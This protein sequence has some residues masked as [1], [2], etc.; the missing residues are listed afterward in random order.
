MGVAQ[1]D[2]EAF[3]WFRKAAEKGYAPAENNM[4]FI[5]ANGKGVPV[6]GK[7]ALRWYRAAAD[8]GVVAAEYSI[9]MM[10]LRGIA[11]A[12]DLTEAKQWLRR[13]AQHGSM[14][15]EKEIQIAASDKDPEHSPTAKSL[16]GDRPMHGKAPSHS[17][18]SLSI[19]SLFGLPAD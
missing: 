19:N 18:G 15:A 11:V 12:Q 7:Q 3:A 10:Y 9:G 13:A 6:D 4:G 17:V 2:S 14:E 16:S 8:K 5:Y 1:S